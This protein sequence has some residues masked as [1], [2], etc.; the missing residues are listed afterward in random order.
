[1]KKK[2][3]KKLK[4]M[5]TTL[6]N[7]ACQRLTKLEGIGPICAAGLVSSLGD[8]S[9][10]KNGRGASAYIV[11]ER[12][13]CYFNRNFIPEAFCIGWGVSCEHRKC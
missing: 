4:L 9:G 1:L 2:Q 6:K 3:H 7:T 10:F 8:G 11:P 13:A 5:T 12:K